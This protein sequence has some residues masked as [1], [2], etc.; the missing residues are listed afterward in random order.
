MTILSLSSLLSLLSLYVCVCMFVCV[1][2]AIS[3]RSCDPTPTLSRMYEQSN[4]LHVAAFN[5]PD[6]DPRKLKYLEK[7]AKLDPTHLAV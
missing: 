3:P 5:L 2:W 1:R 7:A 6:N 4:D